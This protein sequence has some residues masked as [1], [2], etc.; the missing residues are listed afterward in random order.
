MVVFAIFL[1]LS[2]NQQTG[3]LVS[4]EKIGK[5]KMKIG[6]ICVHY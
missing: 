5:R 3:H 6:R 2:V 1:V 4:K